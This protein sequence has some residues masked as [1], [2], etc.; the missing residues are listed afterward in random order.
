MI[1]FSVFFKATFPIQVLLLLWK[2][3]LVVQFHIFQTCQTNV[4]HSVFPWENFPS[5]SHA[6]YYIIF[7]MCLLKRW[8][9]MSTPR[10]S[11]SSSPSRLRSICDRAGD[12][13]SWP[14]WWGKHWTCSTDD[15]SIALWSQVTEGL[16][17]L[18]SLSG[19][20]SQ[21]LLSILAPLS[22]DQWRNLHWWSVPISFW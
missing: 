18:P 12:A 2:L 20:L 21:G 15:E 3:E 14:R 8:S 17:T 19:T 9:L 22:H 10:W 1:V 16:W 5:I 6:R 7:F 13:S 11:G 4:C